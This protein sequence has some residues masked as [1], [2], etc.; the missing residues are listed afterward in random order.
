MPISTGIIDELNVKRERSVEAIDFL[1]KNIVV[2][3]G[4]IDKYDAAIVSIDSNLY[5][6]VVN[7]NQKLEAVQDAYDDRV[8]AGCRTDVFWRVAGI[9]TK[10]VGVGVQTFYN[11]IATKLS[12]SGYQSVGIGSTNGI[13]LGNSGQVAFL[14]TDGS[15]TQYPANSI[16]GF[17]DKNLYGLKYYDEPYTKGIGDTFVTSFIGTI[18]IGSSILTVMSPV[19]S[20]VTDGVNLNQLITSNK[21]GIFPSGFGEIVG[22]GTTTADLSVIAGAGTTVGIGST[23][24]IV[25]K[26]TLGTVVSLGA[27]APESDGSFVTFTIRESPAGV[28]TTALSAYRLEF[29]KN[30]FA[31]QTIGILTTGTSGLGKSVFYDNSGANPSTKSWNPALAGIEPYSTGEREPSVGAGKIYYK[32]GFSSHPDTGGGRVV[33]GETAFIEDIN[34]TS[35]LYTAS[36]SCSTEETALTNAI[37]TADSAESDIQSDLGDFNYKVTAVNALRDLRSDI[38]KE[39]WG[40]RQAIGGQADEIEKYDAAIAYLGIST[41]TSLIP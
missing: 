3:D 27:S 9:S 25:P 18:S 24:S 11:L 2:K 36:P 4:E 23:I 13:A 21:S 32:V 7:V 19:G 12:L 15:Y 5:D 16:F 39:I 41:I 22:I 10:G 38:Q 8:T 31:P 26:L 20:G 6:Q 28:G 37:S 30:P 34:L 29:G 17:Q 33:E 35:G 14:N 40:N 1:Q